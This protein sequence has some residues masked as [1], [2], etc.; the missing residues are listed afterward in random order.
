[1]AVVAAI[2][3]GVPEHAMP[4]A[5]QKLPADIFVRDNARFNVLQHVMIYVVLDVAAY[6]IPDVAKAA[7]A[8]A[9]IPVLRTVQAHVLSTVPTTVPAHVQLPVLTIVHMGAKIPVTIHARV[10]A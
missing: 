7:L 6:A 9:I 2:V 8:H 10:P 1:M 3:P 5:G 4:A